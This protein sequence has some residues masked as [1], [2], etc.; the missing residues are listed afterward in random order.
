MTKQIIVASNNRGKILELQ[1]ILG[2][3]L[4]GTVVSA[5]SV[6]PAYR[7]AEETGITFLENA[8]LKARHAYKHFKSAVIADD[9]GLEVFSLN[10]EPGVYSARYSGDHDDEA[11]NAKLLKELSGYHNKEQ[12]RAQ[13]VSIVVYID[14]DGNEY[15][16]EGTCEG[17]IANE[18]KGSN[19]FGY[20]P[21]FVASAYDP[22]TFG[23]I[24]DEEKN[25]ISHRAQAIQKLNELLK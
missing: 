6:D 3:T 19:G 21:L 1:E 18:A 8:L 25:S 17:Y 23:E 24:S 16:G 7:A 11:N 22:K 13:F 14:D 5:R 12:R 15:V 2:H 4:Q 9:S 10:G 20:D